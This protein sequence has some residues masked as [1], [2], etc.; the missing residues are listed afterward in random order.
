MPDGAVQADSPAFAAPRAA[1]PAGVLANNF[2]NLT[3]AIWQDIR[4]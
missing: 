2:F 3:A 1:R 4:R